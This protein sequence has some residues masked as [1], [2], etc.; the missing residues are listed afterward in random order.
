[1]FRT[2]RTRIL[3]LVREEK[4]STRI[5]R[6]IC[7]TT[8]AA[9]TCVLILAALI[10]VWIPPQTLTLI[11]IGQLLLLLDIITEARLL[12]DLIPRYLLFPQLVKGWQLRV[13]F[14]CPMHMVTRIDLETEPLSMKTCSLSVN[15]YTRKPI[16][17]RSVLCTSRGSG[18]PTA[19]VRLP[20]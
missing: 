7:A 2:Q 14:I 9:L 18:S 12:L 3:Q 5:Q 13:R 19:C 17:I 10:C 16:F 11:L 20:R 15:L 6:I 4:R 1:M 8:L